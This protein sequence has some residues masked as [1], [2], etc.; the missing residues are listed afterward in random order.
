MSTHVACAVVLNLP[1]NDV[2]MCRCEEVTGGE[3]RR[4]VSLGC[5]G[6]NQIKAFNRCGMGPCQGRMCGL[7]VAEVVADERK[8]SPAEVGY[9][10]IRLPI[11]PITL[12]QLA[13]IFHKDD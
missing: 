5:V 3:I 12:G 4:S 6:P 11:K 9:Y 10:R 7:T 1:A 13:G 2:L 8:A